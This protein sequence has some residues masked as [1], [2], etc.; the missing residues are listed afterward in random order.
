MK[1]VAFFEDIRAGE[2]ARFGGKNASLG[3]MI[4]DLGSSGVR[5]PGGFAT[6]AEAYR[7]HL[8]VHDLG[9]QMREVI[10]ELGDGEITD[11][12]LLADVGM[13]LRKLVASKPLPDDV[14]EEILSAYHALSKRYDLDNCDVAV[15]S[16]ATAE[17]LPTASFAGQH[18]SFLHIQGDAQLLDAC[19]YCMASLF[20]DRAIVYRRQ[21]GFGDFDVAMS[22][23]VQKMVR[24]DLGAAG[25]VFT[26]DPES[27]FPDVITIT[28]SYGLGELLVQ[29]AIN[30]DEFVVHKPTLRQGFPAI[31]RR[32]LGTK[33]R[34]L[35]YREARRFFP[36]FWGISVQ[37]GTGNRIVQELLNP[38]AEKLETKPTSEQ[39]Q[40]TYCLSNAEVLELARQA[41]AIEALYTERKGSWCPMDI[42]WA[43]DGEDNLIY[44]VQARPETVHGA[45]KRTPAFVTYQFE[46]EP[47]TE[48]IIATGE[49]IGY[50]I[51]TGTARV[52]SSPED[53]S[54]FEDGD[55]LVADMTD[56]DWVPLIKRAGGMVTNRGGR[57]CHAAIVSRE[58][59]IPAIIGTEKATEVIHDGT[60]ITLDCASGSTGRVFAGRVPSVR[61]R[62]AA[63]ELT[64]PPVPLMVNLA[65]PAQAFRVAQLPVDGVGLTRLEFIISS[66]IGVHPMACVAA[67]LVQDA[68]VHQD[69]RL[70]LGCEADGWAERYV[71]LLTEGIATIAAAFY[72]RPVIVRSTDLKSN[73]YRNLL[74]GQFF[75]PHEENPTLGFRGAARYLESSYAPA[76]AL[77]CRAF[78]RV[79]EELGLENVALLVPFVR[80]LAEAKDVVELLA[81][82]GLKR[83]TK[84]LEILMMVEVPVNVLLLRDFAHHFDGFSIGSNDLTQ[85]ILGVD[86]DS[87]L[88][89]KLYDEQSPA[90]LSMLKMAIET[91][92]ACNRPIGICGQAPTDHPEMVKFLVTEGISSISLSPD[93][94]L[95]FLTQRA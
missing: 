77:E 34:K 27:G 70:Q 35:V 54:E 90:V 79:R 68:D 46:E 16:S 11:L 9:G 58:L 86:R 41:D 87:A 37:Q 13:R 62:I 78:A 3:E 1:Y 61:R 10:E 89:Q 52:L 56:P 95:P 88:V 47:P 73:E 45:E 26:L 63:Q 32:V 15:R 7:H 80:S 38:S 92:R 64:K 59:G 55:I 43:K 69:I 48:A 74:G 4:H 51:V 82:H 5:V 57:T 25:V 28:G 85:L 66:L 29:G 72:P 71:E 33:Q 49:A 21:H 6:T 24:S 83:Q 23:G 44:I 67:D 8:E 39:E 12:D 91:A 93:A 65:D 60:P 81:Q 19:L 18:E 36:D 76:F 2:G 30:P 53:S 31:I 14:R 20:T 50:G 75:E 17:D 22:V 40:T 84:G 94:V 42:E